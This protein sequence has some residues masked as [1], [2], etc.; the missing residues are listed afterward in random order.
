MDNAVPAELR[1]Q[2]NDWLMARSTWKS[3]DAPERQQYADWVG[4]VSGWRRRRRATEARRRLSAGLAWRRAPL[5]WIDRWWGL[6]KNG[7]VDDVA[8]LGRGPTGWL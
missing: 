5:R 4:A 3:L 2:I 8:D 7:T 6:P 1:E